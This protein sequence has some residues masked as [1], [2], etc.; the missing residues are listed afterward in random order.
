MHDTEHVADA[1]DKPT[2]TRKVLEVSVQR[3]VGART[4]NVTDCFH[5]PAINLD[6]TTQNNVVQLH[7]TGYRHKHSALPVLVRDVFL[8][9]L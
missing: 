1:M 9:N 8:R 6:T 7:A 3:D 2:L 5:D 4:R